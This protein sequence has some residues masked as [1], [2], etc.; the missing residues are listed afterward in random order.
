MKLNEINLLKG[1]VSLLN[2]SKG[3]LCF[4]ILIISSFLIYK[5]LLDSTT[6]GAIITVISTIFMHFHTKSELANKKE[7][8]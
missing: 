1:I 8:I 6:Y 5:K 4:F 2:S 3:T 7:G